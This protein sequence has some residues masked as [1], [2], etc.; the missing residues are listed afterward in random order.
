MGMFDE[1]KCS[2]DIA[3]TGVLCQTKSI[4][5]SE[6]HWVDPGDTYGNQTILVQQ[7]TG[8]METKAGP[9]GKHGRYQMLSYKVCKYY[10]DMN[11]KC[12]FTLMKES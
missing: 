8:L 11:Q 4:D 1:L 6:F 7:I 9:N 12:T 3:F 2:A 5:N 10:K